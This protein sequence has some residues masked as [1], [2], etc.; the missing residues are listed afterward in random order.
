MKCLFLGKKWKHTEN[1]HAC[2][3]G[4][5][6]FIDLPKYAQG[7][8]LQ[9]DQIQNLK[10]CLWSTEKSEKYCYIST[11]FCSLHGMV[12]DTNVADP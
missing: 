1:K 12:A 10:I 3:I 2:A 6:F 8:V 11:Y 7:R 4:G 5:I 9:V